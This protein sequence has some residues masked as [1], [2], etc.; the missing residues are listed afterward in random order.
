MKIIKQYVIL[1]RMYFAVPSHIFPFSKFKINIFFFSAIINPLFCNKILALR[2]YLFIMIEV[3]QV[4][5]V[6]D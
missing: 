3:Q 6:N 4:R 2:P 1:F 5:K